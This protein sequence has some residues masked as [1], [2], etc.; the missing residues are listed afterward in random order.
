MSANLRPA[1]VPPPG[2]IIHRELDARG[3]NQKELAH[4][5]DRPEQTISE[6][7]NG[8]KRITPKTALELAA[9]FG[10]SADLWLNLEASYQLYQ[11]RKEQ[12]NPNIARKS[13]LYSL[14]PLTE[15][16]RL[17]WIKCGDALDEIEEAVCNFL[18]ITTPKTIPQLVISFRQ[19][20]IGD[21]EVA[22]EIAW[23][24][25]VEHLAQKQT[26]SEFD[27]TR[28]RS[29][30]PDLL[31][32][33]HHAE[34]VSQIP[35]FLHQL[36]VHF[37]IV[38]HLSKTYID[39]AAFTIHDHPTVALTLRHDRIDNFWFTLLHELA[40]II[41]NHEGGYLD[42]LSK[43]ADSQVEIEANQMARDWLIHPEAFAVFK[44][45]VTA[46]YFSE[47]EIRSFAEKQG[48]H[49]GIV[50]GQLHYQELVPYKNLRKLLVPVKKHLEA[51]IDKANPE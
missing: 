44:S 19:S 8:K 22:G 47:K 50:L 23:I 29:A 14:V 6:I 13:R 27:R 41:A 43:E 40:H 35:T 26:V 17:G 37:V 21:P 33:A 10:T 9:A 2:R 15:I 20:D 46:P 4:I 39:G 5:M 7:V 11:A 32:Y 30:M 3:W 48:R 24:K 28:L 36:G 31:A 12:D 16:R 25:R 49:P 51:W 38:P 34:D 45:K 42:D 1:R 18:D